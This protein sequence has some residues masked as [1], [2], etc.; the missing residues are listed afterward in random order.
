VAGCLGDEEL[1]RDSGL[2]ENEIWDAGSIA[3]LSAAQTG[4][5]I[6][7]HCDRARCCLMGRAKETGQLLGAV[8]WSGSGVEWPAERALWPPRAITAR[9]VTRW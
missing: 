4:W 6:W 5:F 3:A 7:R 1:A 8:A 2:A 9:A